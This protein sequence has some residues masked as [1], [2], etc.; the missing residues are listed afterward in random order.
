M[1][2]NYWIKL[3]IELLEDPKMATLPDRLWRRV[4]ELFLCAGKFGKNGN[5]P[6]TAQ[7]AW[8]LRMSTDDLEMDLKQIATTG[9]IQRTPDGWLVT[10]FA[11]RQAPVPGKERV[12]Q[13]RKRQQKQQYYDDVTQLKRKVTQIQNTDTESDTDTE[14]TPALPRISPEKILCDASNLPTFPGN[15][16]S[17]QWVDVVYQLGLEYGVERTTAAMKKACD[18]WV[19]TKGQNGRNYARTN[20]NWIAWAMEDLTGTTIELNPDEMTADQYYEY[21]MSQHETNRNTLSP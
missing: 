6:E 2:A 8:V 16:E 21:L 20:L 3:Y 5:L 19:A 9:I 7:L 11:D 15:A 4:I 17:R 12:R 18:R 13:F 14:Q 10:K 1:A